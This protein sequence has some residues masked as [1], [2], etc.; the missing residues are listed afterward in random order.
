LKTNRLHGIKWY[1]KLY[2]GESIKHES[3]R[4]QYKI[5]YHRKIFGYF[6]I[7]LPSNTDNLLDII[8]SGT[9]SLPYYQERS[10]DV[11]G[12][13][14]GKTEAFELVGSI[15]DEVYRKTGGFNVKEYLGY[16]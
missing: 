15:I 9:L 7:T 13:A 2:L 10:Y 3:K 6:L 16:D 4:V 1:K 5:I 14:G 11:I 8:Y 12:L